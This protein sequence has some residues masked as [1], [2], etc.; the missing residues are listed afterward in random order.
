M[1]EYPKI[2]EINGAQV[3]LYPILGLKAVAIS[4]L[5][6]AGSW[7]EE[8][9][10]WGKAHLLEHMMFQ[11]TEIF[12]DHDEMEIFK[13]ENGIYCNASTGGPNIEVY[14]RMPGESLEAGL[15]L[16]EEMLF[17]M[18]IPEEPLV[19]QKKVVAQE[20]E[21]RA[22]RPNARFWEKEVAQFFGKG[23]L[24][25]RDGIGKK[26]CFEKATRQELLD[27]AK[28]K[29]VPKN[30]I[31]AIAGKFD[32][33]EVQ[34][35][36][37]KILNRDGE[38]AEIKFETIEPSMDRLVHLEAGMS[39]ATLEMGWL[40][41]GLDKVD[42][43]KRA[44]LWLGSY[45]L[46]G[47]GRSVLY[48]EIRERL[49]LAYSISTTRTYYP[50]IGWFDISTSVKRENVEVAIL[51]IQKVIKKF[52]EE[53]IDSV[54]FARAKKYLIMQDEMAYESAMGTA[55]SISSAIFWFGKVTSTEEVKKALT[56]IS[57]AEVRGEVGKIVLAKEPMVAIMRSK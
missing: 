33:A 50:T 56:S 38:K 55:S 22:S 29:I 27:Y 40:M 5:I 4:V 47:N 28:E 21:D 1:E 7:Y 45:L 25:T 53:P 42:F 52:V 6:K 46:G 12:R 31:L 13:E 35:K 2:L 20:Y 24:Y 26:E 15:K 30:M 3:A 18:T 39:T 10:T 8:G 9:D 51:E 57:E 43:E 32:M 49:G 11:G 14:M 37:K 19:K 17:K 36:L 23:H 16:A 44:K 48:K 54:V 41:D 34:E